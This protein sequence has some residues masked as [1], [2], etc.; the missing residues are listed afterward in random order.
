MSRI[1]AAPDLPPVHL[2]SGHAKADE[3]AALLP[4]EQCDFHHLRDIVFRNE[5]QIVGPQRTPRA[6]QG[7][8]VVEGEGHGGDD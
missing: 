3:A 4:G 7:I 2:Q 5:G 6:L 8:A 1:S